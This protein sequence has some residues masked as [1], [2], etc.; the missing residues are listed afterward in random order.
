MKTETANEHYFSSKPS[1]RHTERMIS[2]TLRGR[3]YGFITDASTFSKAK[4]DTGTVLLIKY[5]KIEP[6]DTVLDL[7]CGYGPIG[8]VA[9]S[10][11]GKGKCYMVDINER[12]A[13]LAERNAKL[14]HAINAVVKSG[15][16]FEPLADIIFD[17]ILTN[18]PISAG[19]K[20]VFSFIE[21]SHSHLGNGGRFY[22][23]ARTRQGAKTIKEK[24]NA[25]FGNSEC[26]SIHSGY[27]VLMSKKIGSRINE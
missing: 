20:T 22:L 9:A 10:L 6:S 4:V 8:I 2:C 3:D 18:P 11:A 1:S 25:V 21:Q 16:M 12:S 19:R 14:N 13:E 23:V 26:V 5:M 17:V 7:G 27:R 15:N 24:M